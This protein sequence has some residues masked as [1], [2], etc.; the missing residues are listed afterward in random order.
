MSNASCLR[1]AL[2]YLWNV[3]W[4]VSSAS[5]LAVVFLAFLPATDG[6]AVLREINHPDTCRA[7]ASCPP[8]ARAVLDARLIGTGAMEDPTAPDRAEEGAGPVSRAA[9]TGP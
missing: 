8:E 6:P 4:T 1:T 9:P 5:V 2:S 3:V 7:C